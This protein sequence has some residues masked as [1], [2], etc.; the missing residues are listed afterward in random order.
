M[1]HARFLEFLNNDSNNSL[2]AACINDTFYTYAYLKDRVN[3]AL[4]IIKSEGIQKAYIAVHLSDDIEMYA[5]ILAIW[6]SGNSYVPLHTGYPASRVRHIQETTQCKLVFSQHDEVKGIDAPSTRICKLSEVPSSSISGSI[7]LER[8]LDGDICYCL[9]TSGSTGLPKGVPITYSNLSAFLSGFESLNIPLPV[10]AGYLQMFELTFDLSIV[11][12]LWAWQHGGVVYHVGNHAIK[13][14]EI[15]R[16]L[17]EYPVEF[18]IMVPSIVH[19]LKPYYDEIDWT[20]LKVLLF[21]GEAMT[22]DLVTAWE[23]C[24]PSA[25]CFNIYGP[26]ECTIVCTFYELDRCN[27]ASMN[28]IISIGKPFGE[29]LYFIGDENGNEVDASDKGLLWIGG[30]QI[31]PGYLKNDDLSKKVLV[32]KYGQSFYNTGD[33]VLESDSQ[34]YYLGRLDQQVKINGYRIELSEIEFNANKIL[35]QKCAVISI[36]D[37]KGFDMLVLFIQQNNETQGQDVLKL[38]RNHLPEYMLPSVAVSIDQFPLNSNGKLD[39][40][41]LKNIYER[42]YSKAG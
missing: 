38:L 13:Y 27:V 22:T 34:I 33:L 21:C 26:T 30:P 23:K 11:S 16:I 28:G 8:V 39:R 2:D 24:C 15:S 12:F 5:A 18:A 7:D 10:G 9:F 40:K 29:N 31:M 41:E 3:A 19:L 36:K 25:R 35:P 20:R 6:A 4:S 37:Q 32:E 42:D 1:R 14:G 17:E